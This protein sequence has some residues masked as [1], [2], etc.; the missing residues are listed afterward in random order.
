MY[1]LLDWFEAIRDFLELGGPVLVAIGLL[2][3]VMW[4]LIFERMIYLRT[5]HRLLLQQVMEIWNARSERRSWNA[6]KIRVA[7]ISRVSVHANA[8]KKKPPRCDD[9]SRSTARSTPLATPTSFSS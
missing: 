4:V 1:R 2:T 3:L 8:Y 6:R 5:G 7:L 9:S